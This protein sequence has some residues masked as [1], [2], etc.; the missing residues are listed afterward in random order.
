MKFGPVPVDAAEGAT[1]AH[2]LTIPSGIL[3]K[4]TVL[5]PDDLDALRRGD[6]T[7]VVVARFE[8]NSLG[9]PGDDDEVGHQV[10]PLLDP[11]ADTEPVPV[12]KASRAPVP[13]D[14]ARMALAGILAAAITAAALLFVVSGI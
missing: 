5:G 10:F 2:S 8:G 14:R 3:R 7:T 6:V 13:Q 11:E 9:D 4:G 12:Y 1:L